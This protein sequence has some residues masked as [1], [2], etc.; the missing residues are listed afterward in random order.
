MFM[1][2]QS[3]HLQTWIEY[4]RCWSSGPSGRNVERIQS[5]QGSVWSAGM[6]NILYFWGLFNLI[7]LLS[8][9][10]GWDGALVVCFFM[11]LFLKFVVLNHQWI[12]FLQAF[13]TCVNRFI[14]HPFPKWNSDEAIILQE[15]LFYHQKD[16]DVTDDLVNPVTPWAQMMKSVKPKL[17]TPLNR[18]LYL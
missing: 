1:C 15:F 13:E 5:L 7:A 11:N 3:L 16:S 18:Y 2:G 6:L 17:F 4:W 9:L 8:G 14:T 10:M 12:P